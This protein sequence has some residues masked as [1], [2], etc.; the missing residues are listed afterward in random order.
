MSEGV[1]EGDLGEDILRRLAK[2]SCTESDTS[3]GDGGCLRGE[4]GARVTR[5][6]RTCSFGGGC[7]RSVR[8]LGLEALRSEQNMN[9]LL[10]GENNECT[11]CVS[12]LEGDDPLRDVCYDGT[13]HFLCRFSVWT[14]RRLWF[15]VRHGWWEMRAVD[16]DCGQ[17]VHASRRACCAL[18]SGLPRDHIH[19]A[20]TLEFTRTHLGSH[21]QHPLALNNPTA[22]C[23][24]CPCSRFPNPRRRQ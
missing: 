8:S 7:G 2:S 13:V 4:A 23:P 21:P 1:W 18:R 5:C 3:C 15:V 11:P 14:G 6:W 10:N 9:K 17:T 24:V 19:C 22:K 12:A 20:L 16:S